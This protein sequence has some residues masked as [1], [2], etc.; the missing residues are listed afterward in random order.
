LRDGGVPE[1]DPIRGGTGRI[2]CELAEVELPTAAIAT[3]AAS[4]GPRRD[5]RIA[6]ADLGDGAPDFFDDARR[7]VAQDHGCG[8]R[9]EFVQYGKVAVAH[10][11]S[12]DTDSDLVVTERPQS[13]VFD[14]HRPGLVVNDSGEGHASL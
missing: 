14:R 10:A 2:V 12:P 13:D 6:Y 11:A 9:E 3:L 5:D 4:G 7:L 1:P 8:A